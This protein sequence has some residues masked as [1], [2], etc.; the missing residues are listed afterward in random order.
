[1][2]LQMLVIN[3]SWA[4]MVKYVSICSGSGVDGFTDHQTSLNKVLQNKIELKSTNLQII[5]YRKY[6]SGHLERHFE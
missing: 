1:M 6:G 3:T 5:Q 4:K 2:T